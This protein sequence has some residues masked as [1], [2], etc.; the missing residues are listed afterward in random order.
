VAVD[1]DIAAADVPP[2]APDPY[3]MGTRR[4]SPAAGNPGVVSAVP[5]VISADPRPT[6]VRA[7]AGVL[8]DDRRRPRSDHNALS[9]CRR[10]AQE[11]GRGDKEKLLHEWVFLSLVILRRRYC[12]S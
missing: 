9:E 3:G 10:E 4:G 11:R 1:P 8:D 5:A 12:G 2:V 7:R 6:G